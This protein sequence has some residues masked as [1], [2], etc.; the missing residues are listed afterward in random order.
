MSNHPLVALDWAET[1][2]P[3]AGPDGP[4][5]PPDENGKRD[6]RLFTPVIQ[7]NVPCDGPRIALSRNSDLFR[8]GGARAAILL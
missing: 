2:V 7:G 5:H 6:F 4:P 1:D 8:S 3:L